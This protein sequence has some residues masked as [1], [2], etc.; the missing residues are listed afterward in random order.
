[1]MAEKISIEKLRWSYGAGSGI[2]ARNY[3]VLA[4]SLS[5]KTRPYK[6]FFIHHAPPGVTCM[7]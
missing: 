3:E 6:A 5:S 7:H 2:G 4:K 1:M